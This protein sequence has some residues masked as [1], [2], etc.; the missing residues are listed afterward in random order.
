MSQNVSKCPKLS[1]NVPKCPLQTHRFPNGL[2]F[3]FPPISQR[4]VFGSALRDAGFVFTTTGLGPDLKCFPFGI[5]IFR[6][7]CLLPAGYTFFLLPPQPC[8]LSMQNVNPFLFYFFSNL[9]LSFL[10]P[11][12]RRKALNPPMRHAFFKTGPVCLADI[13]FPFWNIT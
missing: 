5:L 12:K 10:G 3:F 6:G 2:V 13:L 4:F 8:S 7:R 11:K 1:Q 9:S